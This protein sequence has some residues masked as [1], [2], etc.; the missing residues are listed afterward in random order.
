MTLI[1]N[2]NSDGTS[3]VKN[4]DSTE[5]QVGNCGQVH[6]GGSFSNE[7]KIRIL[8]GGILDVNQDFLNKGDLTINDS[9]NIANAVLEAL[10]TTRS[11]AD[12]GT[13]IL[14][15]LHWLKI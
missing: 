13:E 2:Q 9:N 14:K 15:K 10:R 4:T 7:G 5:V 1:I 3:E 8:E 6:V 12:L 11:V